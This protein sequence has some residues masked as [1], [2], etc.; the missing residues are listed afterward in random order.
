MAIKRGVWIE[1]DE[2][3]NGAGDAGVAI[4]APFAPQQDTPEHWRA[5]EQDAIEHALAN[6]FTHDD[7][8]RLLCPDCSEQD[9]DEDDDADA[10]EY[11]DEDG[12]V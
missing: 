2:C 4:P 11:D 9:D 8:D 1:C 3:G 6:Y 10:D 5:A 7:Q 12:Y